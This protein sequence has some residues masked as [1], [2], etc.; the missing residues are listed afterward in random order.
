MLKMDDW[1][2]PR[3]RHEAE[4]FFSENDSFIVVS[5]I[6]ID[7]LMVICPYHALGSIWVECFA[8][9]CSMYLMIDVNMEFDFDIQLA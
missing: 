5:E 9:S 1:R 8:E 4:I 2:T 3:Y 7:A 6:D